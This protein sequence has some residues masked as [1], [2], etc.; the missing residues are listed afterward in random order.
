[1][2]KESQ[3]KRINRVAAATIVL[4]ETFVEFLEASGIVVPA[5][6]N[7]LNQLQELVYGAIPK[8]EMKDF[9]LCYLGIKGQPLPEPQESV[10]A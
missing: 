4:A 7:Q 10:S 6:N 1:M 9:G 8:T 5:I 3:A 2:A